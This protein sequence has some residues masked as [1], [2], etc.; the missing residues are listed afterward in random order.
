M[1]ELVPAP[2]DTNEIEIVDLPEDLKSLDP[3]L[4]QDK[5]VEVL[6]NKWN[7]VVTL[8]ENQTIMFS[9]M[10][11]KAL[12]GQSDKAIA[13]VVQK[14]KDH[15]D[16]KLTISRDRI[17][18]GI[19]LIKA[20]PDLI[21]APDLNSELDKEVYRKKDGTKFYEFYFEL[22]KHNMPEGMRKYFETLGI[23]RNWT[24]RALRENIADYKEDK[25]TP[26]EQWRE[27]KRKDMQ[28]IIKLCRFMHPKGVTIVLEET[29]KAYAEHKYPDERKETA[30]VIESQPQQV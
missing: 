19:R 21:E 5:L 25:H 20:R 12:E 4:D 8:M 2:T 18:Q 27:Q 9:K 7:S 10:V 13:D 16:L 1:N 15:P 11:L 29:K 23:G 22:Y 3:V 24:V 28:E 30:I 14:I 26:Q 17:W 6:V